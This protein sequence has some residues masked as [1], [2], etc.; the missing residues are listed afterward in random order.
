MHVCLCMYVLWHTHLNPARL[1]DVY[2]SG[3]PSRQFLTLCVEDSGL[4][5]GL[6]LAVYKTEDSC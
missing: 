5:G 4:S 1:P 2:D 6:L 3:L